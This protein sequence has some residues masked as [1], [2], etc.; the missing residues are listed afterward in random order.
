M[1]YTADDKFIS[2]DYKF[3]G[4][5][6]SGW[7]IL[8]NNRPHLLLGKGYEVLKTRLCGICSTD[9]ARRYFSFSLPQITGHEVVVENLKNSEKC[10]V[11]INDTPYYR[12]D[13]I[14]DTFCKSGLFTH[15]PGRMVLGIDR[16]PGGFGP[17][18][19]APKKAVIP[20]DRMNEHTAVL[21]EPFAAA[22]Q[23]IIASPPKDGDIVA[24][25]GPRKLGCLLIAALAA[26]RQISKKKYTIYALGRH[27]SILDLCNKLGADKSVDMA[28]TGKNYL[29]NKFDIVFDTTGSVSGFELSLKLTQKEVHIKSTTGQ[30]VCGLVNLT[31][32]VVD[33]LSLLHFNSK[34]LESTWKNEKRK[35]QTL[36]ISPGSGDVEPTDKTI[37]RGNAEEANIILGSSEFQDRLPRFDIGV[38][39]SLEEIDNIIRPS[40]D[41]ENSLVRPRGTILFNGDHGDNPLLSFIANGGKLSSSRCGNFK[42]AMNLLRE[43]REIADSMAHYL[44]S[45]I[46]PVKE[47]KTAFA[48]AKSSRSIKVIVKHTQIYFP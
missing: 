46:F 13:E 16:L 43:N 31:P 15:S 1:E 41:N 7:Q 39:S 6:T 4:D 42:K 12:G 26:F 8:K 35:N 21:I 29:F 34:N 22:L 32:F 19:L 30:N 27:K 47:L 45:H 5:A 20:I 24:V 14:Q 18:I 28:E 11:E 25:L 48:Y 3:D 17:Y 40:A 37:Y 10:V 33:E 23:A 9:L 2:A 36:Y 38:A 44:I